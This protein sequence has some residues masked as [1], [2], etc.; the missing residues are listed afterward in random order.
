MD[1]F[2][3]PGAEQ[4]SLVGMTHKDLPDDWPA[5][6]LDDPAV[7]PDVVDLCVRDRD[8]AVGGLSVLYCR[9]DGTLGQPV[10]VQEV[11]AGELPEVVERLVEAGTELPGVGGVVVSVVRPWGAVD[12]ADR[13][14]HQRAL[15]VCRAVGLRLLGM[16]VVTRA[17]VTLLPVADGLTA[18]RDVA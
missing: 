9:R 12:D 15:D 7:A 3:A 18:P 1:N 6:P 13:A 17:G 4:C 11:A 16:Y 14:A 5:R 2:C 8:R 10:F